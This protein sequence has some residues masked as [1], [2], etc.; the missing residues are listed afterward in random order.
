LHITVET[1]AATPAAADRAVQ[2]LI[3]GH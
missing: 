3:A 1:H 2:R